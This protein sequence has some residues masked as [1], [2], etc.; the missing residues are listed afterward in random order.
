VQCSECR[1]IF[2][3]EKTGAKEVADLY[4]TLYHS[5]NDPSY[6]THIQQQ[7]LIQ[8]DRQ[9]KL[10]YNKRKI[11]DKIV[12]GK[13][14]RIG[15]IGAGVGL[16]GKYLSEKGYSYT[17]IE[18]EESIAVAAAAAGI[19]IQS[20]SFEKLREYPNTFDALLAFE[21][22]EH[23][24]DLKLCLDLINSSLKE[25]GEFG[26]TVPNFDKRKNDKNL[27]E[28]L[29]QPNPPIHLNFFTTENIPLILKRVGFKTKFLKVRPL[30]DL[31]LSKKKTWLHLAKT[32]T[33]NFHGSTILC[34]AVKE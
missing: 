19:N 10:G 34:V 20:G 11:I 13:P 7:Q 30:P 5:G 33:G 4:K 26:F 17:G 21:V 6:K 9:P 32:L 22:I 15:E 2:S 29:Y 24:D 25:K 8:K 1:L 16:V 28:E 31:V 3:I 14:S 12:Q 27:S 23:I 18:L